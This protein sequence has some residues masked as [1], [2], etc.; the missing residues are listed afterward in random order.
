MLCSHQ[1]YGRS[2]MKKVLPFILALSVLAPTTSTAGIIQASSKP[3]KIGTV[4]YDKTYKYTCASLGI[5]KKTSLPVKTPQPVNSTPIVK[6]ETQT[7]I[8]VV[9]TPVVPQVPF[10]IDN[11]SVPLVFSK[12]RE[13]IEAV[14]AKS[15]YTLSG[16][17]FYVAPTIDQSKVDNEKQT[18]ERTAKLWSNIYKPSGEVNILFYDYNSL[19][20]AYTAV[21][22]I[23][24]NAS[25]NSA[26][27]CQPT[28]CGNAT[29]GKVSGSAW[30]LEEG[31]G[32]GLRNRS[33]SSHEYTHLAQ[34]STDNQ[35]WTDAPLWIV[36]GMAQ[37]YGEVV[38]YSPFDTNNST[39][40]EHHRGLAYDYF[41]GTGQTV[42]SILEKNSVENIKSIMASIEF[43]T[44]R[45]NP[46]S[47]PLA[48]LVGAYATE[49]LVAVYGH[50]S[51]EKFV[52]SFGTS[53]DWELNF[54]NSFGITKD[55]F[56][57]KITPYLAEVSKEL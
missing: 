55:E 4:K 43:P 37:Y 32:G 56:Y 26:T 52:T 28:Y 53:K 9:S 47:A 27:S 13:S 46:G 51:F 14:I 21:K 36:E 45:Y 6:V 7:P 40:L 57:G 39:R 35:Y 41:M 25:L 15:P 12:S 18:I 48:Y 49:V 10:S 3:C 29:A 19:S 24:P 33:T 5:W 44:P 1:S 23:N 31:L 22:Q 20:W 2:I 11:L 16:I 17:N 54:K 50:E 30:V 38:G 34:A 42:K 8:V